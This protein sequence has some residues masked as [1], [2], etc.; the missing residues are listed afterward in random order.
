[1]FLFIKIFPIFGF[2]LTIVCID[3]ARYFKRKA[4]RAWIGMMLLAAIFSASSVA[5]VVFRGDKNADNWF[6]YITEY[7]EHG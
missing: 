1:M 6:R 3:L 4:N 7:V 5:W 2:T